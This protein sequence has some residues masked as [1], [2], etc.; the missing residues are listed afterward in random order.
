MR[1]HILVLVL[2]L[3]S[4]SAIAQTVDYTAIPLSNS[5]ADSARVLQLTQVKVTC[6]YMSDDEKEIIHWLNIARMY[7]KWFLYLRKVK[8][9]DPVF[10][11]TLIKT[12]MTMKPIEKKLVPDK[13][14]WECAYCHAKTTGP[15][16]YIGHDRQDPKCIKTYN[17]ECIRYGRDHPAEAVTELLIDRGVPN[18]GHRISM[19]NSTYSRVGVSYWPHSIHGLMTVIDFG[20]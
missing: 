2:L 19:L 15:T 4:F 17:A 9:T 12:M 14:L 5:S 16:K 6:D 11:R 20:R 10:S 18:L 8:D 13:K 3:F 1:I 7:P